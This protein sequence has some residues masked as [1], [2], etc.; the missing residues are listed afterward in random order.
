MSAASNGDRI[1]GNEERE[2]Q[3]FWR[4]ELGQRFLSQLRDSSDSLSENQQQIVSNIQINVLETINYPDQDEKECSICLERLQ[5]GTLVKRLPC[6]HMFHESCIVAWL[7]INFTCP[8]CRQT[9]VDDQLVE[10]SGFQIIDDENIEEEDIQ[11]VQQI[12]DDEN[13]EEEDIQEIQ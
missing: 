4:S 12:I 7:Q 6:G 11:E 13:I 2:V 8:F 10:E 5:F 9:A 3:E 1:D